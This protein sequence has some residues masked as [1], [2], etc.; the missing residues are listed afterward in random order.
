M[1]IRNSSDGSRNLSLR[2]FM[3]AAVRLHFQRRQAGVD[4]MRQAGLRHAADRHIGVADC[5]DLLQSVT[6]HDVV[7]CAEILV[8]E[9]NERRRLRL[10]G[11]KRETLKIGQ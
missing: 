8:K 3:R 2:D 1:P 6:G 7:E 5:L 10:L 9:T 4:R 11:Q